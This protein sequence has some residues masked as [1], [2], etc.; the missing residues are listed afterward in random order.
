[1]SDKLDR[2]MERS[3]LPHLGC[4]NPVSTCRCA[5]PVWI[6][7]KYIVSGKD[8][9]LPSPGVRLPSPYSDARLQSPSPDEFDAE[10]LV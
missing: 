5:L 4:T 8:A 6:S 9:R 7:D 3:P 1:M 10:V 2:S